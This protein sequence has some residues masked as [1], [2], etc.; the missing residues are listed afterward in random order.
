MFAMGKDWLSSLTAEEK[1]KLYDSIGYDDSNR[2]ISYPKKNL[3]C[4]T[5]SFAVEGASIEHE[6]IPILTSDIGVYAPSVN[7][8]FTL[9]LNLNHYTWIKRLISSL[10]VQPVEVVYDEHSISEVTAF[11]STASRGMDIKSAAV[12]TFTNVAYVSQAGLQY[13]IETYTG[14]ILN[15]TKAIGEGEKEL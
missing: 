2:N 12:K 14:H 9:T 4:N 11:F 15:I 13:I 8:V 3:S 6:L 7:Q 10:N 1:E 5:E